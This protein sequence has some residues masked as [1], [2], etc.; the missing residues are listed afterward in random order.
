MEVEIL[1]PV[2]MLGEEPYPITGDGRIDRRRKDIDLRGKHNDVYFSIAAW[3]PLLRWTLLRLRFPWAHAYATSG[4]QRRVAL[5]CAVF[6][7]GF[8]FAMVA[9]GWLLALSFADLIS[10]VDHFIAFGLLLI[11]GG[12]MIYEAIKGEGGKAPY[13]HQDASL[14]SRFATSIDALAAGVSVKALGEGLLLPAAL[15]GVITFL[16]SGAGVLFACNL[17]SEKYPQAVRCALGGAG[18]DSTGHKDIDR[19]SCYVRGVWKRKTK[20]LKR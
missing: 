15:T 9:I 1:H 17:K 19:A 7:G 4:E 16:L 5:L 8:Q 6:F 20:H 11:I 2:P 14:C 12:H 3:L 18:A 10:A 13:K